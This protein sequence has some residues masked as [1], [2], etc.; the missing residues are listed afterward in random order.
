M[1]E[2]FLAS[3][4]WHPSGSPS[5]SAQGSAGCTAAGPWVLLGAGFD[6]TSS[7]LPGS[8]FGPRRIREASESLETYSPL[9]DR[10]LTDI[11]FY[12]AGDLELPH[13][14]AAAAM[15]AIRRS[16]AGHL[17]HG[18]RVLLLGGEHLV[19]LPAVQAACAVHP[20]L[21]VVH[22]DAHADLRDEY[23]SERFSHATVMRRV[24]EAVGGE[25][26]LQFAIRSGSRDEIAWGR[27]HTR[28]HL[29][30]LLEPLDGCIKELTGHPVY[31][32]V[33]I[34]AVDPAYAPGTGTPEP[35]GVA[36]GELF[37]ALRLLAG[38]RIVGADLVEM[39]PLADSGVITAALAAKLVR[40]MLLC[41]SE[42]RAEAV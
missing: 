30:Q 6:G 22:I 41:F 15:E 26:L 4:A 31:V 12:D 36:P 25:R 39:N 35:A 20:G 27:R 21:R 42:S 32:T 10:D 34:D 18:R 23:L 37:E 7:F 38:C 17:A 11:E 3:R 1:G 2:R 28:L 9:L 16:V 40:E 19:T 24:A 5:Q 33:D 14:D 8:R 29:H 13:G